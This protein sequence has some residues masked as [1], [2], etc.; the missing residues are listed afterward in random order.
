M[1]KCKFPECT[2]EALPE[3]VAKE[4]GS[5]VRGLCGECAIPKA[6]PKGPNLTRRSRR[7]K[8]GSGSLATPEDHLQA[9]A[10]RAG[11]DWSDEEVLAGS[12]S[13]LDSS[14]ENLTTLRGLLEVDNRLLDVQKL[15]NGL[16]YPPILDSV[17]R[18]IIDATCRLGGITGTNGQL[19]NIRKIGNE[20]GV[21]PSTVS[22]RIHQLLADA[23]PRYRYAASLLGE[24]DP[25]N[26]STI[27]SMATAYAWYTSNPTTRGRAP[28]GLLSLVDYNSLARLYQRGSQAQ[29]LLSPASGLGF[30]RQGEKMV[31]TGS[32]PLDPK[33]AQRP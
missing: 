4:L 14:D 17:E 20:I 3:E 33:L 8:P 18:E 16:E 1:P 11:N 21:A 9:A 13:T 32:G 19:A 10:F 22:R 2:K 26:W 15:G 30:R 24:A 28:Q 27:K 12:L 7:S 31:I 25:Q 29:R 5:Q 23:A 6:Y